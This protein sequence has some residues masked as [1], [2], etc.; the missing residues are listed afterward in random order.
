MPIAFC[1][2]MNK[3]LLPPFAGFYHFLFS[4]PVASHYDIA[5]HFRFICH[6]AFLTVEVFLTNC[7]LPPEAFF[8]L[9]VAANCFLLSLLALAKG[10]HLSGFFYFYLFRMGLL[11]FHQCQCVPIFVLAIF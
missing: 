2:K 8:F 7:C 11:F 5:F 3:L 10:K 1:A 9:A 4:S 6:Y